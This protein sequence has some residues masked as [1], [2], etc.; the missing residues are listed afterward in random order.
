MIRSKS[1]E[2]VQAN[3]RRFEHLNNQRKILSEWCP[4][5][6]LEEAEVILSN[7]TSQLGQ[8][9]L[10]L[11]VNGIKRDGF[12]VEFGAT[13]GYGLSNS[14]LLEKK[15]GWTGILA[16]PSEEYWP[17][18]N[19]NR[20]S[21][22][23]PRCVWSESGRQLLFLSSQE[24]GSLEIVADRDLH[25]KVRS[26]N[27]RKYMV[28]TVS[29]LDLLIEHQAP[30]HVDFLSI[31]TEGSE[32]EILSTFDFNSY[33]FGLICVEHN[34]NEQR[35]KIRDLLRASGYEQVHS[36]LSKWDDWYV[37]ANRVQ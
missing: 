20:D 15:F 7:A 35:D 24:L 27:A 19:S 16:E 23:D 25:R 10:A 29:L 21:I 5:V 8:D 33:S 6:S 18:L 2:A 17:S 4:E 12:F 9:V 14:Y 30:R 32:F 22:L 31:D 13:D 36:D 3:V 11:A 37:N 1:N 26:K 34:F 28:N